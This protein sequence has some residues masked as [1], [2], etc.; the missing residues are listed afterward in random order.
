MSSPPGDFPVCPSP[1][2]VGRDRDGSPTRYRSSSLDSDTATAARRSPTLSRAYNLMDPDARERQR[3]LDVDMAIH[4]SR[5]RQN[6]VSLSPDA[7]PLKLREHDDREPETCTHHEETTFPNLFFQEE[8]EMEI[9][10]GEMPRQVH[11]G[12][13]YRSVLMPDDLR[14][15]S[16]MTHHLVHNH[17]PHIF[18]S[19]HSV[20]HHI[21]GALPLYQPPALIGRQTF[22][23]A[24]MENFAMTEKT[25]LG[26][27]SSP[28][29]ERLQHM[30]VRKSSKVY[31]NDEVGSSGGSTNDFCLPATHAA[32]ERKL[33]QSIA[34]PRRH[35]GGKMALF[36]GIPGAPPASLA[37]G[38]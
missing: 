2:L 27:A 5:A 9:A 7:S 33:S 37:A 28:I 20:A 14:Q 12:D 32:R 22:N 18:G 26:L 11:I 21:D 17:E 4:L 8:Q 15:H 13:P 35:G 31:A 16:D 10:R 23:F 30:R 3:T 6:S 38:L 19:L 24:A 36:E 29:D 34:L 1:K 25:R